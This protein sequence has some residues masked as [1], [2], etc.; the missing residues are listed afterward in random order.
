MLV[1]SM[2]YGKECVS[3]NGGLA[4]PS[5]SSISYCTYKHLCLTIMSIIRCDGVHA[6][7]LIPLMARRR[8]LWKI[9]FAPVN[10][11]LNYS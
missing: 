4:A 3:I 6:A 11:V 7:S 5:R 10:L 1:L 9:S 8:S 2:E